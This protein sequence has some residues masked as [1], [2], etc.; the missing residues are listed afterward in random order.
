MLKA[1]AILEGK[2]D[3]EKEKISNA[4]SQLVIIQQYFP[5][6]ALSKLVKIEQAES[7][8]I[9]F[10]KLSEKKKKKIDL[11]LQVKVDKNWRQRDYT[12]NRLIPSQK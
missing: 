8:K 12:L 3:E 6:L 4:T 7:Y 10:Q 5:S 11:D 1:I 2:I 9:T